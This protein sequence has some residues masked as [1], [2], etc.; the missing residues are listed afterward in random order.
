MQLIKTKTDTSQ[1]SLT[2]VRALILLRLLT[3]RPRS[4]EEIRQ[5][6]IN[7]GVMDESSSYDVIRIDLNTLK[8]SGCEISRSNMKTNFKYE[9]LQN[10]FNL[11]ITSQEISVL[12][13]AYNKLKNILSVNDLIKY[14]ELFEKIAPYISDES[15]R[16]ELL[17]ISV[18]KRHSINSI[19]E[20][21]KDAKL[22]RTVKLKYKAASSN[23]ET[24]KEVVVSKVDCKNDKIYL[25]GF[26]KISQEAVMLHIKR[27][28]E[29]ISRSEE[30]SGINITPVSVKFFLKDFGPSGLS[31]DESILEIKDD[32]Y[33]IE[34]NYHN[35]F[36]AIQR[37]LS[38][39]PNCTVIS[40]DEFKQNI[41]EILK[42]MKEIY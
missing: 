26:D 15:V 19:K 18:L 14:D 1:I 24:L 9:L 21:L 37:I 7:M 27:I 31:N 17:G 36:I 25:L 16:Q 8:A 2:G 33:V 28:K 6:F 32:G 22:K 10:P 23:T 13:R 42:K 20:F 3:E 30:D 11:N 34:G 39:G 35:D 5:Y 41:I 4:I 40:P 12:K 29:I 38:F